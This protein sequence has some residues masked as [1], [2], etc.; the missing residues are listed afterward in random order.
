M[1]VQIETVTFEIPGIF[2]AHE[3]DFSDAGVIVL[4]ELK[5][6]GEPR[7]TVE[8]VPALYDQGE[9]VTEIRL[10]KLD[11]TFKITIDSTNVSM[12][13][14]RENI[15]SKIHSRTKVNVTRHFPGRN[16]TL[17]CY[18][19]AYTDEELWTDTSG[20][21]KMALMAPNPVKTIS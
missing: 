9:Y 16:E 12:R 4:T 19:I 18:L 20:T 21:F 14:L 3:S 15:E 6:W 5:G 10:N 17:S 7:A 11:I 1:V 8:T 2:V 13:G